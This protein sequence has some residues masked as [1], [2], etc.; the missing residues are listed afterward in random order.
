MLFNL[1]LFFLFQIAEM[2]RAAIHDVCLHAKMYAPPKM[3]VKDFLALAPEPPSTNAV[4]W[5]LEFLEVFH[6]LYWFRTFYVASVM[7]ADKVKF[8]QLGAL[9]NDRQNRL[10]KKSVRGAQNDRYNMCDRSIKKEPD[11]TYL[12][13]HIAQLPLDPQLARLLLFGTAFKCFN[14]TVTLV[15]TLSHREPCKF[16]WNVMEGSELRLFS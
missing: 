5:S 11:L 4:E 13:R 3:P 12:G 14:P 16:Y 9:H 7:V 2:K 10:E 15:A 1:A 8:Q 6:F